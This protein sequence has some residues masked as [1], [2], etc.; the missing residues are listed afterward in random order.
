MQK[1]TSKILFFLIW[2]LAISFTSYKLIESNKQILD[3]N[4]T[5]PIGEIVK[6]HG[7]VKIRPLLE[8]VW[9]DIS[10]DQNLHENDNIS[11]SRESSAII[12]IDNVGRIFLKENTLIRLKLYPA[13]SDSFNIEVFSGDIEVKPSLLTGR[14]TKLRV[15]SGKFAYELTDKDSYLKLQKERNKAEALIKGVDGA[16]NVR[17][18]KKVKDSNKQIT[19]I[20]SADSKPITL[21]LRLPEEPPK[22][23]KEIKEVVK[24]KFKLASKPKHSKAPTPKAPQKKLSLV[25]KL[26]SYPKGKFVPRITY[27][28]ASTTYWTTSYNNQVGKYPIRIYFSPQKTSQE[29]PPYWQPLVGVIRAN[30]FGK[31]DSTFILQR[32]KNKFTKQY[33]NI[34]FEQLQKNHFLIESRS[35]FKRSTSILKNGV[36]LGVSTNNNIMEF[37][38][39]LPIHFSSIQ[40]I[41]SPNIVFN[42]S[43]FSWGID[44]SWIA[45][46]RSKS[47]LPYAL[48]LKSINDIKKVGRYVINKQSKFYIERQTTSR[49]SYDIF[50]TRKHAI[51]GK[52]KGIPNNSFRK[53]LK[54]TLNADALFIGDIRSYIGG[55]REFQRRYKDRPPKFFWVYYNERFVRINRELMVRDQ[56]IRQFLNNNS[57]AFFSAP[58]TPLD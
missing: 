53:K 18:I 21:K 56:S 29:P 32:G 41:T 50:I 52:I 5:K 14:K 26:P 35:P 17:E 28:T 11:T 16:I 23:N 15:W 3:R 48:F 55:L 47:G 30:K 24:P 44:D 51:I 46:S 27:P 34:Y 57:T 2:L 40:D 22:K 7:D 36:K 33:V 58:I 38:E 54:K 31:N 37:G 6:S 19:T 49:N 1:L 9:L 8:P 25:P 13:D 10:K 12:K 42:L 39:T 43:N 4:D 20:L 45:Q